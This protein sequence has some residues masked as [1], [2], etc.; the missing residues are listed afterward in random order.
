MASSSINCSADTH[1]LAEVRRFDTVGVSAG[2]DLMPS[3]E[4]EWRQAITHLTGAGPDIASFRASGGLAVVLLRDPKRVWY[5]GLA[6][7][8]RRPAG[9]WRFR[10]RS[11]SEMLT[12]GA[13]SDVMG[14]ASDGT[15]HLLDSVQGRIISDNTGG[16]SHLLTDYRLPA[17]VRRGCALQENRYAFHDPART[18]VVNIC[19]NSTIESQEELV[20][21]TALDGADTS[22]WSKVQLSGAIERPCIVWSPIRTNAF[23]VSDWTATPIN[24]QDFSED[25]ASCPRGL[26]AIPKGKT[27]GRRVVRFFDA[28]GQPTG[29]MRFD[30]SILRIGCTAHRLIVLAGTNDS[31]YLASYVLPMR[32]RD[33]TLAQEAI[34]IASPPPIQR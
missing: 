29:V 22:G 28:T 4:P 34:V 6:E 9:T 33:A 24:L 20:V 26:A 18:N 23:V 31:T 30:R 5:F 15:V 17:T 8:G 13:P 14:V 10:P 11:T 32:L 25:M 19:S 12:V 1:R 16:Y 3:A 2:E 27:H 21:Q 7:Q